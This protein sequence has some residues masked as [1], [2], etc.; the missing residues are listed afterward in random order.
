MINVS[1]NAA[2]YVLNLELICDLVI[3]NWNFIIDVTYIM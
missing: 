3:G 1:S 2:Y